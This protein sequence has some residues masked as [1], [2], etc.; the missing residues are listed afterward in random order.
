MP[1]FLLVKLDFNQIYQKCVFTS[2]NEELY[3][4]C[5]DT[6][7]NFPFSFKLHNYPFTI[8]EKTWLSK[9]Y[10]TQQAMCDWLLHRVLCWQRKVG[11]SFLHCQNN[12]KGKKK[13]SQLKK[14]SS[15][16]KMKLVLYTSCLLPQVGSTT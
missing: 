1:F 11:N 14:T 12:Q 3:K 4:Y 8:K 15:N 9:F 13:I 2:K 5:S 16:D 6:G 7:I 10:I